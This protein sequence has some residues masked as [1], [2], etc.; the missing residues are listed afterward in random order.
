MKRRNRIQSP[1]T[2]ALVFSMALSS[3]GAQ[4]PQE[5]LFRQISEKALNPKELARQADTAHGCRPDERSLS[6]P[7]YRESDY[8]GS[9]RSNFGSMASETNP[10]PPNLRQPRF[11]PTQDRKGI[12]AYT[13]AGE[14]SREVT[15]DALRGKVVVLF[16]FRP[17]CRWSNETL[18]EIIRLQAQEEKAG[19]KVLCVSLGDGGWPAVQEF[20]TK[21]REAVP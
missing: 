1:L 20:K 8:R 7:K 12:G 17:E 5:I 15:V 11:F 19:I 10:I 4:S 21:Q 9:G 2:G 13:V 6:D 16:L 3:L 18:P 14:D